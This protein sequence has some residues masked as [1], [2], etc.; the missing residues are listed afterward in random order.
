MQESNEAYAWILDSIKSVVPSLQHIV[1]VTMSDRLVSEDVLKNA[2]CLV[3]AALCN[4]HLRAR[5]LA[6]WVR[7]HPLKQEIQ[8]EFQYQLQE[9]D[10]SEDKWNQR[11]EDFKNKWGWCACRLCR[12]N[13]LRKTQVGCTIH[14]EGVYVFQVWKQFG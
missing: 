14:Q 9:P 10:I 13:L 5:N 4:W 6:Y 2:F 3:L 7:N 1:K 11:V 8:R 12:V